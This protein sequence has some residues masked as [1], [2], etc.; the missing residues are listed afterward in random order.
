MKKNCLSFLLCLLCLACKGN[1]ESGNASNTR[2][3]FEEL[4]ELKEPTENV[5][6]L[7]DDFSGSDYV[8]GTS[9]RHISYVLQFDKK[10]NK[11]RIMHEIIVK[12]LEFRIFK[13]KIG[14]CLRKVTNNTLELDFTPFETYAKNYNINIFLDEIYHACKINIEINEKMTNK[15]P[16]EEELLKKAKE[17]FIHLSSPEE[18]KAYDPNLTLY[19]EFKLELENAAKVYKDLNPRGI[20]SPD[21][22][23]ITFPKF[24]FGKFHDNDCTVP[25][26]YDNVVFTKR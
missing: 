19:K 7:K 16:K 2:K 10:T 15:T 4:E 26:I 17:L 25:V 9:K 5:V 23:T 1:I 20:I 13:S 14:V 8:K 6:Y 21:K 3:S 18:Y 12:E 24:F 22:L 11:L